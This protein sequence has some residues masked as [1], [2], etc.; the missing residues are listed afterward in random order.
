M[1]KNILIIHTGGTIGM[2]KDKE[3]GA[4]KPDLFYDSIKKFVPELKEIANIDVEIPFLLDSADMHFKYWQEI[5]HIIKTKISDYDGFVITHG[6]DTLAYTASALS[7][8]LVNLH[9]PVIL[10]GSQKPLYEIRTDARSNLINAVELA[11]SNIKEVAIFFNYKLMRGNRTIKSNIN[12]F[13]AFSSPNYPLLAEV[14]IDINIY[15]NN[16]LKRQGLFHVL[17]KFDNNVAV[18]KFFPGIKIEEIEVPK[19]VRAIVLVAYGAGT[20]PINGYNTL[21]RV[22]QWIDENRIV[23]LMSETKAGYVEPFL[24]ES[25]NMFM[26]LGVLPA[27]DMTFEAV[28]TKIMFLLG[29]YDNVEI[30]KKNFLKSI[31]GELTE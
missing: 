12:L 15:W 20:L 23:I 19:R 2:I 7:Y 21:D 16:V 26:K 13:D 18:I 24:Y 30:I 14:G 5:A 31:A 3:T 1:S 27:G 11:T 4:L 22:K 6:T 9:V 28:I 8:M 29:Q 17:D 25:G 10:T